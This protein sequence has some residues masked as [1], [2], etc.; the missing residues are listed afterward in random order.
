MNLLQRAAVRASLLAAAVVVAAAGAYAQGSQVQSPVPVIEVQ[1]NDPTRLGVPEL[2][3]SQTIFELTGGWNWPIDGRGLP[4]SSQSIEGDPSWFSRISAGVLLPDRTGPVDVGVNIVVQGQQWLPRNL[5]NAG[6]GSLPLGGQMNAWSVFPEIF[7]EG[8][9]TGAIDWQLALGAGLA[10][11][12]IDATN[13]G[14]TVLSGGATTAMVNFSG[15]LLLPVAPNIDVGI[16]G[17]VTWFPGYTAN[18][19][20]TPIRLGDQWTG[21]VVGKVRVRF[22]REPPAYLFVNDPTRTRLTKADREAL[23][24]PKG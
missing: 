24:E 22:N 10:F 9:L 23:G 2:D 19:S 5:V 13:G 16:G 7:V 4:D 18:A 12:N 21:G 15:G 11:Q 6:G 20:G 3:W 8:P 1:R 14:A 17:F